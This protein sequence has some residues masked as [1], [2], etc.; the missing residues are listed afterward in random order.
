M[1]LPV[2]WWSGVTC[3]FW[4]VLGSVLAVF[5][6]Q[7]W[8]HTGGVSGKGLAGRRWGVEGSGTFW[9]INERW[10][11]FWLTSYVWI[12]CALSHAMC[13]RERGRNSIKDVLMK[14]FIFPGLTDEHNGR[15]RISFSHILCVP[16]SLCLLSFFSF[17]GCVLSLSIFS[18]TCK[19]MHCYY[20][21]HSL[22]WIILK[23]CD[24]LNHKMIFS[25]EAN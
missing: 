19:G 10:A 12:V 1:N 21:A 14:L 8:G 11:G 24:T 3:Y 20:F 13:G 15:W 7:W 4:T 18:A 23:I 5:V 16:L 22:C 25:K 2:I 6:F 17:T 9:C